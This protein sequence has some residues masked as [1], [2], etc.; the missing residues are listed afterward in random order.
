MT[1]TT[2][3]TRRAVIFVKNTEVSDLR[4]L[5]KEFMIY[6][7]S[8]NLPIDEDTM[9]RKMGWFYNNTHFRIRPCDF[10]YDVRHG[11]VRV[12]DN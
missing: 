8:Q 10:N 5:R 9:C 12:V 7:E 6:R 3:T 1:V 11:I 2:Q 4:A